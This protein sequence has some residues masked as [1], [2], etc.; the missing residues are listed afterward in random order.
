VAPGLRIAHVQP[1]SIDL[2]GFR[3]DEWGTRFRYAVPNLAAAQLAAGDRPTVHLL[4]GDDRRRAHHMELGGIDVE[5]HPSVEPQPRGTTERRFSRQV[6]TSMLRAI[7]PASVD[8]VHFHGARSLHAMLALVVTQARRRKVPVVAQDHGPRLVGPFM[9][10]LQRAALRRCD[11]LMAANEDSLAELSGK[12]PRVEVT[13]VANG[14]DPA[15]FHPD[16]TAQR[17]D[18]PF[19]VLVVSRLMA[20]KDPLTAIDACADLARRGHELELTV[21]GVGA[22]ADE[23]RRRVEAAGIPA[24]WFDTMPQPELADE[25]RRAHVLVLSSLREGF[26]QSTLEAMACGTPVVA[27]DIPGIREGVG[28]AGILLPPGDAGAFAEHLA[29]LIAD[30]ALRSTMAGRSIERAS[31][32]TWPAISEQVREVYERA[33]RPRSGPRRSVG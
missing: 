2:F 33:I 26:N 1:L 27:S 30:P 9:R 13:M 25:Y 15:Q 7:D 23:V 28:D 21:V 29:R 14:V 31:S 4:A 20:D 32:Y 5:F 17:P 10:S 3:D 8:V 19:R 6:S 22:Q 16:E 18:R 12:A 24:R 11:A